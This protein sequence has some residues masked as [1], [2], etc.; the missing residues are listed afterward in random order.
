[1]QPPWWLSFS[2]IIMLFNFAIMALFIGGFIFILV[3]VASI[4]RALKE[5]AKKL[6]DN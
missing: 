5:I 3:K 6:D 2:S 4:D 1:M